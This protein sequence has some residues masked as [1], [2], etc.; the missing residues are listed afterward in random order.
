MEVATSV[1]NSC[2]RTQS[3]VRTC[4]LAFTQTFTCM[5]VCTPSVPKDFAAGL[6]D[7]AHT[8]FRQFLSQD[9]GQNDLDTYFQYY[10]I[11]T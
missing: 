2:F 1:N 5:H 8:R 11:W 6:V 9:E 3:K 4:I 10:T 7:L